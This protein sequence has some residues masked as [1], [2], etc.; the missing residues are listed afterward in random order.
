MRP[1]VLPGATTDGLIVEIPAAYVREHAQAN[2]LHSTSPPS[3]GQRRSVRAYS[4]L[5]RT[6]AARTHRRPNVRA[7][8]WPAQRRHCARATPRWLKC[9]AIAIVALLFRA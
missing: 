1:F 9:N 6:R 7:P 8:K 5:G 3:S 2:A 4:R